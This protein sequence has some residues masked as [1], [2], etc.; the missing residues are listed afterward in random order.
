MTISGCVS[1]TDIRIDERILHIVTLTFPS[2]HGRNSQG[3]RGVATPEFEVRG[4]QYISN[5][6]EFHQDT[7]VPPWQPPLIDRVTP[8]R[9][10]SLSLIGVCFKQG[11]FGQYEDVYYLSPS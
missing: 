1:I 8:M 9:P 2:S 3:V 10:Q 5:P 6:P 4:L 11:N 7:A